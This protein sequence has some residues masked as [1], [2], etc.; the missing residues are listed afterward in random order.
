MEDD[1][2]A[3]D[4]RITAVIGDSEDLDLESSV[5]LYCEHLQRSLT[6]PCEVTGIEDFR[7]EEFYVIGPGNKKEYARLKENQPSYRD[8]YDL[9]KI[10]LGPISDW[11]LFAGEDIAAYVRRKSDGKEF[12]LGLADLKAV[13]KKSRNYQLLDDFAVFLVNNR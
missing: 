8:R 4:K 12:I 1:M 5:Q 13:D 6:L 3:Q 7:W 9:L 2:D 10:E 11:M